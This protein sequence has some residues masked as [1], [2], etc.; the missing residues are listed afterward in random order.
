[1]NEAKRALLERK[2]QLWKNLDRENLSINSH[3]DVLY[4]LIIIMIM[5][6]ARWPHG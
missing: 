6:E 5:W 3:R 2:D 4:I 1:V